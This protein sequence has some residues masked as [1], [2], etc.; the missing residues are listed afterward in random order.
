MS[1]GGSAAERARRWA[2]LRSSAR[3]VRALPAGDDP[4]TD[5]GD[6]HRHRRVVAVSLAAATGLGSAGLGLAAGGPLPV[7]ASNG[8]FDANLLALT[9]QDRTAN[10]VGA[11]RL[12]GTLADIADGRP[13]GCAGGVANGRTVD[14]VQRNYFAHEIPECG[15]QY[16]D[17]MLSPSGVQWTLWGENIAWESGVTDPAAAAAQLNQNFMNSPEHKANIL[18]AG[19]NQM[20]IGSQLAA[21]Y[22]GASN[23]WLTT[24]EFVKG[25]VA[26]G[27]IPPVPKPPAPVRTPR[28][29]VP[30]VR[31]PV[32]V[33]PPVVQ[34]P[35]PAPVP[36][37]T[38]TP[39]PTPAPFIP[40][41]L[42][43]GNG[44]A[45]RAATPSPAVAPL[46]YTPQGLLSDSVEA[47]LEVHLLD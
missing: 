38:P 24:E 43:P 44:T 1:I 23:A 17:I 46:L 28:P 10:G 8:T 12:N 32:P 6:A 2:E 40:T 47:V 26:G 19:F 20:G 11:V 30:P 14:M 22:Q 16:A 15:N 42:A 21:S 41:R 33:P 27:G 7:Y 29:I 35:A 9:N 45:P 37:P 36:A 18:N 25:A 5:A 4:D 3:A 39:A 31:V 34:A 13:F